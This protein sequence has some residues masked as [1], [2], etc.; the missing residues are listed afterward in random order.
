MDIVPLVI[1][2]VVHQQD[3]L[4]LGQLRPTF[5]PVWT[6]KGTERLKQVSSIGA[7]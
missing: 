4:L 1:I 6:E 2:Y 5:P 3:R 7:R